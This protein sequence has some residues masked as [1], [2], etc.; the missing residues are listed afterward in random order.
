MNH[1]D[2]PTL[3]PL[4][5][6]SS[7]CIEGFTLFETKEVYTPQKITTEKRLFGKRILHSEANIV[8]DS[9]YK[10]TFLLG[11]PVR[12]TETSFEDYEHLCSLYGGLLRKLRLV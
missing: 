8:G 1:T 4:S 10:T 2:N 6:D 3:G 7:F 5:Y 11:I 9:W 12:T